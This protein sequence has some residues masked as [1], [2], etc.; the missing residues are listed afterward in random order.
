MKRRKRWRENKY[1]REENKNRREG[2]CIIEDKRKNTIKVKTEEDR[3]EQKTKCEVKRIIE[4]VSWNEYNSSYRLWI[5][6]KETAGPVILPSGVAYWVST[7]LCF[8]R[9]RTQD[10]N[11]EYVVT[12]PCRYVASSHRTPISNYSPYSKIAWVTVMYEAIVRDYQV[13]NPQG[14]L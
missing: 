5:L 11:A 4:T 14:P 8:R 7:V 10:S 3:K 12:P 6:H 1:E 2:Q 13:Y 9:D